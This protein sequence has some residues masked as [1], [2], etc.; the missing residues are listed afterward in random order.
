MSDAPAIARP[1]ATLA[2]LRDA[3]DGLEVLMLRRHETTDFA[4][5]LVF[6]GGRVDADDASAE[7]AARCR[8][9]P[10][11]DGAAL[12]FRIAAV[13]ESYEELHVLLARRVGEEALIDGAGLH[14]LEHELAARLGRPSHF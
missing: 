2:L 9:V 8:A 10:G 1:A 13:R 7:L 11:G 3:A 12:A 14:A 6:P 4:G 5:A